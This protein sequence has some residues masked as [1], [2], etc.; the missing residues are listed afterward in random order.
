MES[1]HESTQ[2]RQDTQT[3]YKRAFGL[4]VEDY[5]WLCHFPGIC[6]HY[7]QPLSTPEAKTT[8]IHMD[9]HATVGKTRWPEFTEDAAMRGDVWSCIKSLRLGCNIP[10]ST[11]PAM[12]KSDSG[13]TASK[14]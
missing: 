5:V 10:T 14:T 3:F 4:V 12:I 11:Q 8:R 13:P 1:C 7:T 2:L 9:N 6:G